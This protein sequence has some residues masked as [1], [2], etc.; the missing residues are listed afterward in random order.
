MLLEEIE[1]E[2][3]FERRF[4]IAQTLL[5]RLLTNGRDR[6][7]LHN[8]GDDNFV[9]AVCVRDGIAYPQPNGEWTAK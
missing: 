2:P 4:R 8:T 3:S 6:L 5:I 7:S 1:L 9:R